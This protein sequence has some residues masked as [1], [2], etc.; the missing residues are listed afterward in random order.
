MPGFGHENPN[1]RR[2]GGGTA[3]GPAHHDGT[4]RATPDYG[5]LPLF[6]VLTVSSSARAENNY[7]PP[8]GKTRPN[9]PRHGTVGASR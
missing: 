7:A 4:I 9:F 2:R 5:E 1:G 8:Q 3:T 6:A